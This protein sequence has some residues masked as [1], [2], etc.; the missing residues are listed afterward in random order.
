MNKKY[1][2][3]KNQEGE[4]IIGEF[5]NPYNF[6]PLSNKVYKLTEEEKAELKY[7]HDIPYSDQVSGK[8]IINFETATPFCIRNGEDGVSNASYHGKYYVPGTSVKGMIK[9]VFKI[10]TYANMRN[11]SA[12][13]RYS[14]RDLR[15]NAYELK[16]NNKPQKSGFLIQLYGRF[17]IVLCNSEQL[18]Y[19]DIK[20]KYGKYIYSNNDIKGK[21]NILG[22]DY[23][24]KDN[25]DHWHMWFFS[26]PMHNKKHEYLFRVPDLEES[27][28]IPLEEKEYKDFI[29]IHQVENG[30]NAWKF[31]EKKLKNY[32]SITEIKNDN[33]KG[34]IPC[35]FRTK[36][37]NDKTVV[38]DLGFSFLYRQPYNN[39]IHDCLPAAHAENSIDLSQKI[40]GFSSD[41]FSLKGRVRFSN[42][43]INQPQILGLQYHLLGAPKPTYY[44]FYLKQN[45]I[46][47][48]NT[49]FSDNA[50]ISGWKRY[51]IQ[52]NASLCNT[53]SNP[54]VESRFIPLDTG[55]KFQTVIRFH[56]LRPFEL[57]AL[58]AAIT[59]CE[60]SDCYHSLGFAKPYGFGKIKVKTLTGTDTEGNNLDNKI[61]INLFKSHLFEH[62]KINESEWMKDLHNLFYL[63]SGKYLNKGIRYPNLD[64][65]EFENIKNKKL[66]LNNF[67]P[68]KNLK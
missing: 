64:A 67:S 18:H 30:N 15:N 20:K 45:I 6:V 41:Q 1:Q 65:K 23:I 34:I 47:Q 49:Y 61:Y 37:Q 29:F 19:N 26:G 59:F 14:M 5:I 43:F 11:A 3:R 62:C 7:I 9:N 54:K 50:Q 35:F 53:G 57:G 12:N 39:S 16:A 17:F 58:I 56:N 42:A 13:N 60:K 21:Y 10:I 31:W 36:N 8:I 66:S 28:L 33:F 4:R 22:N 48:Q 44:P 25:G 68:Q 2:N 51:I 27:K 63:A 52:S 55:T 24:F 46:G 38:R 40:F 32:T